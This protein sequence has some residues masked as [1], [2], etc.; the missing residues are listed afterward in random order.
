MDA[1]TAIVEVDAALA[2]IRQGLDYQKYLTPRNY[3]E[4]NDLFLE[5]YRRGERY[6]PQYT[7]NRFDPSATLDAARVVPV[8]E[9][10][11]SPKAR[12]L[13]TAYDGLLDEI[14][15]YARLGDNDR[16][17]D[18]SVRVHGTPAER[19][20][21]HALDVLSSADAEGDT[22]DARSHTPEELRQTV[23]ARL[24]QYGFDWTVQILPNMAARVS[25]EPDDHAVYINQEASFTQ[26][27]VRRLQVHEIDTHVLRAENGHARGLELFSAGTWRS[28][29]HEEGL[30]LYNESSHGVSSVFSSRLYAARFLTCLD[31]DAPFYDLFDRLRQLGCDEYL[32]IYVVARI[33]RGISDTSLP[34]GFIKDYVYFQGQLEVAEALERD[35]SLYRSMY[36]GAISLS[37]V[38]V[39]RP[40]I[41]RSEQAGEILLP[42]GL[43]D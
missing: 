19:Y 25:V 36:Y 12:V 22:A 26:S 9:L 42:L 31:I 32:A 10:D 3:N 14:E 34:G 24:G 8:D 27:D 41:E 43:D 23:L 21:G 2:R 20:R 40:E 29:I 6:N 13:R 7:Y 11:D 30:A 33:K 28:M 39:L 38:D 17:T 37:D 5:R 16:F 35:P 15:M 18:L 1:E 4:E